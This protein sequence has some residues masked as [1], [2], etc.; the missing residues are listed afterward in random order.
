LD[1]RDTIAHGGHAAGYLGRGT[2][3]AGFVFDQVRVV[4]QRRVGRQ[5]IVVGVDDADVGRAWGHDFDLVQRRGAALVALGHGS[6]GVGHVGAAQALGTGVLAGGSLDVLQIGLAGRA[7]ALGDAGGDR[8]HSG[9][10]CHGVTPG[11]AW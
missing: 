8:R 6:K 5:Q 11:S 2:Q 4:L 10:K 3:F 1:R 7:T 9:V